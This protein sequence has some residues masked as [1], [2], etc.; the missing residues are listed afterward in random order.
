MLTGFRPRYAVVNHQLFNL[1]GFCQLVA[2]IVF[3]ACSLQLAAASEL[4]VMDFELNDLTLNPDTVAEEERVVT[5][6]PLL[7][8]ELA[9]THQ[10]A[11][12]EAPESMKAEAAKGQG[13]IF[14]RPEVAA[15]LAREVGADWV[16]S[17]R[18]HKASFLFVFLKAQLIDSQTGKI[19]AD[20]VVELKGQ[21]IKLTRRGVETLAQ[22][23]NDAIEKLD[24]I[25]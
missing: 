6:K 10:L 4:V 20:F 25:N 3:F 18:L 15:K 13:Y 19:A 23:I 8:E 5:L 21:Q 22:Q 2:F 12:L 14:D 1:P 16:V 24:A 11:V 9:K 7:D 17:G